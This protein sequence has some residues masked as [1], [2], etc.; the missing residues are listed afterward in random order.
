ML[1]SC[2][3]VNR[4]PGA[5]PALLAWA[6]GD[7][8]RLAEQVAAFCAAARRLVG[9]LAVAVAA[10][11]ADTVRRTARDLCAALAHFG[12]PQ[13]S[14]AAA[15]LEDLGR[16]NDLAPAAPLV[17]ELEAMLTRFCAYLMRKPWLRY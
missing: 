8:E 9:S 6:D 13:L 7:T 14:A 4:F 2:L 11:D 5:I 10:D 1:A 16:C 17:G 3:A 12:V 15:T